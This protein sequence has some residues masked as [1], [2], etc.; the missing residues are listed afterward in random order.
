M[1][2]KRLISPEFFLH[3]KLYDA[4]Q[5]TGL[6]LRVAFP[7]LWTQADRRGIFLWR[8]RIL[9]LAVLPYDHVDFADVLEVLHVEGF[10]ERYEV[11]GKVYGRITAFARW[12]SFHK[13]EKPSDAP[14][15]PEHGASTV[16]ARCE[17]DEAPPSPQQ[18]HG[19]ST[20]VAVTVTST[21]TGTG[22]VAAD[23]ASSAPGFR[24]QLAELLDAALKH[25]AIALESLL[26]EQDRIRPGSVYSVI[27]SIHAVASGMHVIRSERTGRAANAA[28]CMQAVA[29]MFANG[30]RWNISR[31]R[32]YVG[33]IV[34]QPPQPPS[35]EEREA[36]RLARQVATVAQVELPPDT[37]EQA[38]ARR[39][40]REAALASFRAQFHR[41]NPG[42]APAERLTLEVVA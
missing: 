30:E 8:P 3:E 4:E 33:R 1:A 27:G 17:P 28:D 5:R 37:P 10:I 19:S 29:E 24:D 14:A 7:G 12:Q 26:N 32:G 21:S 25:E 2:R 31:W 18:E 41:T 42:D 38:E 34:N 6:P 11:G 15:P 9:K 36:A 23:A 20:P 16:L 22:A 35:A 40:A 39:I 13:D